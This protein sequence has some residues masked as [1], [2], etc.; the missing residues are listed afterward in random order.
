MYSISANTHTTVTIQSSLFGIK[1]FVVK[2]GIFQDNKVLNSMV[3]N[4]LAPCFTTI[5][6]VMTM[7]LTTGPRLNIKTVLS[8]YGDFHVKDKTAVRTSYL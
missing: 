8:T 1:P 7:N 5:S 4:A 6:A 2:T 3:M